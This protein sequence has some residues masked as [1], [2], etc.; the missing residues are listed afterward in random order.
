MDPREDLDG[1]ST[2]G[3]VGPTPLPPP[4]DEL[5]LGPLG[6]G[7][8]L[9]ALARHFRGLEAGR[10]VAVASY[11]PG[12]REDVPAWCRLRGHTL[13]G[14]QPVS[15]GVRFFIRRGETP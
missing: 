2:A 15:R 3:S 1:G 11:D 5:D 10:V 4:D 7:E 12:A 13:L 8:L 14:V 9:M 6:C